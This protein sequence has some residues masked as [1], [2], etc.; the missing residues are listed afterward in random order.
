[1]W[2][3]RPILDAAIADVNAGAKAGKD[4]SSFS[5]MKA[6]G[7]DIVF[8]KAMVVP[9]SITAMEAKREAIKSGG[10]TVPVDPR[11]PK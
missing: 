2:Y 10:F 7:N 4:Y 9:D 11:E 5:F 3:F 6:G 1:M 8:S